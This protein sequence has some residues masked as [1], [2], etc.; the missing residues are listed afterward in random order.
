MPES[1]EVLALSISLNKILKNA[2]LLDI[3]IIGGKFKKKKPTNFNKF[4]G[5]WETSNVTNMSRMFSNATNFNQD[6]GNWKTLNVTNM[7]S[8]FN[9]AIKFNKYIGEW[10]TSKLYII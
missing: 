2:V 3:K 6:I 7:S 5:N 1:P 10:D 8:M 9:N 4:I